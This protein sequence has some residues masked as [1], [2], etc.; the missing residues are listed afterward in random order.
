M[1][2]NKNAS[3]RYRLINDCLRNPGKRWTFHELREYISE[4]LIEEFDVDNISPRQ[5]AE[6]IHNM[7]RLRPMGFEAPIVRS[8]GY[9]YYSDPE[10]SIDQNPLIESDVNSLKDA[11]SILKQFSHLPHYQDL[12]HVIT[13]LEGS[14]NQ[15]TESGTIIQFE[16]NPEVIGLHYIP[17]L[18]VMIGK[19]IPIEI[20]YRPFNVSDPKTEIVHPYL[21]KEFRN[22]WFLIGYNET[23]QGISNYALDRILDINSLEKSYINNTFF[24]PDS[25]YKD[26]IGVSIPEG[27]KPVRI[28]L[29]VFS[30][31]SKYVLTKPLHTSQKIVEDSG[32]N[33]VIEITIIPNYEFESV[34]LG[35][36]ENIE[37]LDPQ[38]LREHLATRITNT[39]AHY[40]DNPN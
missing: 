30:A 24:D 12:I 22:R 2:Q 38:Y 17:K 27:S 9:I 21:L 34:V 18:S 5:L 29:K 1:P 31:S 3:Y 23:F 32:E 16:S 37:V 39:F 40:L 28:L 20:E 7:R 25:H 15:G 33:I 4:K 10:Y 8:K 36:G 26:V 11:L 19:R 14:I 13:K 6:D 35:F